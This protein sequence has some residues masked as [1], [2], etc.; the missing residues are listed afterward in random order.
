MLPTHPADEVPIRVHYQIQ[1][2]LRDL[3]APAAIDILRHKLGL[4]ALLRLLQGLYLRLL[5][6]GRFDLADEVLRCY[7]GLG[8]LRFGDLFDRF[9]FPDEDRGDAPAALGAP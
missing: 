4:Q 5:V 2:G 3:P 6:Q 9:G 1:E 8:E 7:R